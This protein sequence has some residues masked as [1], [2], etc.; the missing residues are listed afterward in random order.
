MPATIKTRQIILGG[1]R[2]SPKNAGESCFDARPEEEALEHSRQEAFH[3]HQD[4][5]HPGPEAAESFRVLQAHRPAHFK[6]PG[7]E[8]LDPGHRIF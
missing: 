2:D 5:F 4:R 8:Q 1:S 6:K 3:L 7:D